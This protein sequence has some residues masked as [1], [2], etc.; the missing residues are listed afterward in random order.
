[1]EQWTKM[2]K[3]LKLNISPLL[4]GED[5]ILRI[6]RLW[7]CRRKQMIASVIIPSNDDIYSRLFSALICIPQL[8]FEMF[9]SKI[10]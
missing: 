4:T 5:I 1:M 8:I 3:E 7:T 10:S 9:C 2:C 6:F